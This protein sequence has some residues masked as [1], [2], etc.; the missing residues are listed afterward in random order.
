MRRINVLPII[1]VVTGLIAVAAPASAVSGGPVSVTP[2]S[3]TPQ[4]AT[5]GTDGTVEVV[6]QLVPCGGTMYAVG[7]F[8]QI[9]RSG[10]VYTRRNAFSFS[11]TT[12]ALTSWNPN[13][14]G[15]V[16]DTIALSDN[17]AT[18]YLG[19]SF[20]AIGSTKV[21]NLAAVSTSTGLVV[22]GFAHSAGGRV[23]T[24]L[25]V[26]S[27]LLAGGYFTNVNGSTRR[28]LASLDTTTGKDDGYVTIGISGTYQYTDQGGTPSAGNAT[29]MWK[30]VANPSGTKALALGVFTSVGGARRQQ[31]FMLDLGTTQATLDA[32]Y[33]AEFN[34]YCAASL[35]FY[36]RA[37][38]WSPTG[39]TVYV[40]TTGYKPAT[41]LGYRTSDPRAGLCDA[42]AAFPAT[43][44]STLSHL[45]INYTGCDSLYSVAADTS[46]VYIGGHERWANN[47]AG[48]DFAGPGA[49]SAPGMG[50]LSPST[51]S[52]TF[53]PT[54]DRGQGADDMRVTPAGL[55]I[56]SDNAFGANACG[57]TATGTPARGHAGICFLPY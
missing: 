36:V 16:V 9:S 29:R 39:S 26:G 37:A 57:K 8:T 48:C 12:G 31:I 49:I 2:V 23:T 10:V 7:T 6:R 3:W 38:G 54:R 30:L 28:Y 11:A 17:C 43:A 21:A 33:S 55:W 22:P 44:S 42:A 27:H 20:T 32:W 1:V 40:A 50:G 46:T 51:G 13:V 25:R 41:G 18:A 24:L 19:G 14:S 34:Q 53:N 56:A 15:S 5:S 45:W 52:L 35:P 47:P 4:I